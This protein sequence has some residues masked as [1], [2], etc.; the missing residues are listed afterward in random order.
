MPS[1]NLDLD[2]VDHPKIKRLIA[3]TGYEGVY[4]L[5]RLWSYVA[6]FHREDGS[7]AS[8]TDDEI[9]QFAGWQG[10]RGGFL[11]G[12]LE[13]SLMDSNKDIHDWKEHAGHLV[14][15][16]E[17]AR[18]MNKKRWESYKDS[19]KDSVKDSY[20]ESS[21]DVKNDP[22]RTP[23]SVQFSTVQ[24]NNKVGAAAPPN[25]KRN[26]RKSWRNEDPEMF[27]DC[28]A[29]LKTAIANWYPSLSDRVVGKMAGRTV[30]RLN[31]VVKIHPQAFVWL[32]ANKMRIPSDPNN[33]FG[34]VN[35]ADKAMHKEGK[36]PDG[37]PR[38]PLC[39]EWA[40]EAR[41][42]SPLIAR[43]EAV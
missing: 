40:S 23:S 34:F 17:R 38:P 9:E 33:W 3:R 14:L 42:A 10:V 15:Y 6:R 1:L 31:R 16:H 36:W 27:D 26:L 22:T 13:L 24:S 12:L 5:L 28:V 39:H 37:K 4:C 25:A 20:K 43:V 29:E 32:V 8:Y 19:V 41:Q 2:F 11:Q 35:T 30:K 18:V 21:K 7:L